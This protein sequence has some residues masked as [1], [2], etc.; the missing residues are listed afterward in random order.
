MKKGQKSSLKISIEN[1]F[2]HVADNEEQI[3]PIQLTTEQA[4][5]PTDEAF[6]QKFS[7]KRNIRTG[8]EAQEIARV[9]NDD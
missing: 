5:C 7:R 2:D 8:P 9:F 6:I 3:S 1:Y 4:N